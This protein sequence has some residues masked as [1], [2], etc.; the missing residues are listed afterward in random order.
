MSDRFT[1]RRLHL[2]RHRWFRTTVVVLGAL[3][4]AAVVWLIYFSSVLEVRTV[5]VEGE[6]SLT[7]QQ[8]RKAADVPLGGPLARVDLTAVEARVKAVPRVRVV[9]VSRSWPHE[10]TITIAERTAVMWVMVDGKY[11]GVDRLGVD[12][13]SYGS[14][15]KKL[16]EARVIAADAKQRLQTLQAM[17]AIADRI[18]RDDP[19]LSKQVQAIAGSTKDSISLDL[20]RGRTVIWG[21]VAQG[22]RKLEVLEQLLEIDAKGYDISAP[23]Q[24]TTSK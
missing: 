18:R 14:K 3:L 1:A 13:R 16:V 21:S 22:P 19:A 7:G 8:V 15:P 24:P 20:T 6:T 23:D 4:V 9:E 5:S 17:A 12:F 10:V 2:R 11:R